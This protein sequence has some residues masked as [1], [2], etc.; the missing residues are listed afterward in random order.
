MALN[1]NL[2][3]KWILWYHNPYDCNWNNDSYSNIYE[4]DTVNTYWKLYYSMEI[5]LPDINEAMYFI[6]KKNKNGDIIWP[7]WE[8]KYN[9][10]GGFWS[11]KV[12]SKDTKEAWKYLTLHLLSDNI[13]RDK[14]DSD[15][16]NGISISP[17]KCFSIIKIWNNNAID[18]DISIL[19]DNIPFLN[20]DEVVYKNHNTNIE[21]DLKKKK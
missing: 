16:I 19:N 8:D 11:F 15:K 7:N 5:H 21:N 6:M 18:N 20:L 17:K 12:N 3:D 13:C 10:D 14:S 2:N 4:I 9:I 1:Y